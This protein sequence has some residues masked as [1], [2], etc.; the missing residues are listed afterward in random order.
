MVVPSRLEGFG[1][2]F[3]EALS[4][5]LPCIGRRAF[6]MPELIEA[7]VTGDLLERDDPAE[8][9]TRIENV[10]ANDEIYRNCEAKRASMLA[11]FNWDRAAR[12]VATAAADAV[13]ER[14]G[15]ATR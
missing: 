5:G 12:D 3:I 14:A 2:V 10:L 1:K 4:H 15:T 13:R 7:G 9:A 11:T 6:A 8:L